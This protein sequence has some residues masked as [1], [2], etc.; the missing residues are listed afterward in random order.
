MDNPDKLTVLIPGLGNTRHLWRE[1]FDV[2]SKFGRVIIP[3]YT[4]SITI[5]EMADQVL[6]DVAGTRMSLV[7][8]SLGG[9]I[10]LEIVKRVPGQIE[11]LAFISASPFAD[12]DIAKSQRIRLIEKAAV[13]YEALLEDMGQFI[14]SPKSPNMAEARELV[15]EMGRELGAIEFC[16][17]Q[18]ATMGRAD[19]C[20][21]LPSIQIPTRILCGE[22]DL[23]TP[24]SG[25]EYL[26][27][28]IPNA[29]IE[30]VAGAGHLLPLENPARVN[31]FLL[32][33]RT[34][35]GVPS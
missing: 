31:S 3:D 15:V 17:Q 2:L 8:F 4:G 14:V 26:A 6:K 20:E 21:I 10:A 30:I 9:Y 13:D 29:T 11:R 25:N 28:H 34:A 19:C 23:I 32:A 7:G 35:N 16:A 24:V 33:W 22:K 27:K 18:R 12:N 1:Q 5:E